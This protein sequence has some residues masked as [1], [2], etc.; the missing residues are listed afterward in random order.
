MRNGRYAALAALFLAWGAGFL[1]SGSAY[2]QS[3]AFVA[4]TGLMKIEVRFVDRN[5]GL[6]AG[7]G[8]TGQILIPPP[9]ADPLL[10]RWG[11]ARAVATSLSRQSVA[12]ASGGRGLIRVGRDIPFAGWF[13]RH[14]IRCGWLDTRTEWREVESALEVEMGAPAADGNL[15]LVVT[16]E[17]SYLSGRTRRIVSFAGERV[18]IALTPGA[19]VRFAPT[20]AL[21]AFYGRLLAGYDPLR[22]VWPLDLVLR[23]DPVD[24]AEP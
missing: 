17:F 24:P 14:G 16:P 23:V 5:T 20:A 22:R 2:A 6:E 11:Q 21:D 3:P 1:S 12:L 13:L 9:P 7:W 8:A 19:E 18:E 10:Q 15:R 4:A